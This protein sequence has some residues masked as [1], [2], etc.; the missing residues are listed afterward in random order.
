MNKEKTKELDHLL[1]LADSMNK[2]PVIDTKRAD[3]FMDRLNSLLGEYGAEIYY[4]H[5]DYGIHIRLS[6][7]NV[8][9]FVG[10]LDGATEEEIDE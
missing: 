5:Y 3:D 10:W 6:G 1:A 8:D 2:G 9:C 4:T 7:D